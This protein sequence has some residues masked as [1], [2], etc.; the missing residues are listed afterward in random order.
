MVLASLAVF[1]G[2]GTAESTPDAT[3]TPGQDA[4][5]MVGY[6]KVDITPTESVPL[7]GYGPYKSNFVAG[8]GEILVQE[9][10]KLLNELH[11]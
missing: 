8:T 7:G 11:G 4:L 6:A 9:Y 3:T 2:C 1:A 5:L 10:G